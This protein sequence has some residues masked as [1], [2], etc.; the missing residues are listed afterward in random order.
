MALN[1]QQFSDRYYRAVD[2]GRVP[3]VE[4]DSDRTSFT[5]THDVET[6]YEG[7]QMVR[8][9]VTHYDT[10]SGIADWAKTTHYA[11]KGDRPVI[12]RAKP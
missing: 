2:E 6:Y 11:A 5:D 1:R 9:H 3:D 4:D 12:A 7:G 10:D 8:Q